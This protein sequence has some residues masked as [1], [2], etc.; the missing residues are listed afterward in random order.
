[1]HNINIHTHTYEY[2]HVY[3]SASSPTMCVRTRYA[4]V[5]VCA[6]E[7]VFVRACV[8]VFTCNREGPGA[9]SHQ[10][11]PKEARRMAGSHSDRT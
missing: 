9:Q 6:H 10:G 5:C 2:A 8:L 7:R 3:S 11:G 1:M 4:C